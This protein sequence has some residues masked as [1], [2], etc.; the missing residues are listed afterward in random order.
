VAPFPA[1]GEVYR[2][3][4]DLVKDVNPV[5]RKEQQDGPLLL[6]ETFML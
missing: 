3:R 2:S 5:A 1:S 6:G 4:A